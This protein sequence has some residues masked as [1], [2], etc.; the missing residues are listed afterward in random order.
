MNILGCIFFIHNCDNILEY[1]LISKIYGIN[2]VLK[3]L[4]KKIILSYVNR[5]CDRPM[6]PEVA[7][8]IF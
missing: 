3:L 7:S 4:S 8:I 2:H 5:L 6:L 1:G